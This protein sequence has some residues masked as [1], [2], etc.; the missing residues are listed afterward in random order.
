MQWNPADFRIAGAGFAR[1]APTLV[2]GL[3]LN[4]K[5]RSV[6]EAEP[7]SYRLPCLRF[8]FSFPGQFRTTT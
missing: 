4:I 5:T 1:T 3:D 8:G 2:V 7:A 6:N